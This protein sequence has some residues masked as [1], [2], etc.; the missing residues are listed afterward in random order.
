MYVIKIIIFR[1]VDTTLT[2][3]AIIQEN[4]GTPEISLSAYYSSNH[5][6]LFW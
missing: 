3:I 4:S 2:I 6:S 1:I 5:F